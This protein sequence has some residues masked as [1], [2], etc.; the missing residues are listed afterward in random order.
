[1][2]DHCYYIDTRHPQGNFVEVIEIKP[3]DP[4]S[5]RLGVSRSLEGLVP[6]QRVRVVSV[7]VRRIESNQGVIPLPQKDQRVDLIFPDSGRV[8]FFG[9]DKTPQELNRAQPYWRVR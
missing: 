7:G 5:N 2:V 9:S 8:T 6:S 4:L 1:M 3:C